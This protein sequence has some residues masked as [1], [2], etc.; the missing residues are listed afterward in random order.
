MRGN[1]GFGRMEAAVVGVFLAVLILNLLSGGERLT[2]VMSLLAI[3]GIGLVL[4]LARRRWRNPTTGPRCP[5]CGYD[6]S[7]LE[8]AGFCPEC[9]ESYTPSPEL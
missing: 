2:L 4:E 7:G 9:G 8:P 3:A 1:M 6:V 5:Y